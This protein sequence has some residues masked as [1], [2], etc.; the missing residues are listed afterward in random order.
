MQGSVE[1]YDS[2]DTM[3]HVICTL[4]LPVPVRIQMG[5]ATA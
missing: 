1:Q 4:S 2:L 5:I 3:K